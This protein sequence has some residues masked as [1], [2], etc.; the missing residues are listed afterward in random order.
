MPRITTYSIN[1]SIVKKA[2]QAIAVEVSK[3]IAIPQEYVVIQVN[4]DIFLQGENQVEG[5][6]FVEVSLFDR[7]QE[8]EDE[9]ARIITRELNRAGC[10]AV[11]IYLTRLEKRRYF[12]NGEHF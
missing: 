10:P 5:E 1:P 11:D 12:E 2:A 3:L 4:Q 7:G 9:V 6:P 8:K